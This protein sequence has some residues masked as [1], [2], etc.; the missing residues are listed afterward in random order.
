MKRKKQKEPICYDQDYI[1]SLQKKIDALTEELEETKQKLIYKQGGDKFKEGVEEIETFLER[2][3]PVIPIAVESF[4]IKKILKA[5][6]CMDIAISRFHAEPQDF[7]RIIK[8]KPYI[9]CSVINPTG[10]SETYVTV[11]VWAYSLCPTRPE[12]NSQL[13][14]I[15]WDSGDDDPYFLDEFEL[16]DKS[17]IDIED[18]ATTCLYYGDVNIEVIDN[19]DR[20]EE[21]NE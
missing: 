18:L 20:G 17:R 5:C 14:R 7:E 4:K 10:R 13:D 6:D 16:S 1:D 21:D 12:Y 9:A 15:D 19:T 8:S 2:Q 11:Q 3:P